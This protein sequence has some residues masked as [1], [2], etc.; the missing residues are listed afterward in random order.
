MAAASIQAV[1][2]LEQAVAAIPGNVMFR[3]NLGVLQLA[4]GRFEDAADTYRAA[5]ALRP[6]AAE[7]HN[8]LGIALESLGRL[9]EAVAAYGDAAAIK[10]E[11]AQAHDNQGGALVKLGRLD[12]AAAAFLRAVAIRPDDPGPRTNLGIC[13]RKMNR[14][15]EADACFADAAVSLRR[16]VAL[17]PDDGEGWARLGHVLVL[18]GNFVGMGVKPKDLA[19]LDEARDCLRRALSL[20]MTITSYLMLGDLGGLDDDLVAAGVRA[21]W[22][23]IRREPGHGGAM[24]VLLDYIYRRDRLDLMHGARKRLLRSLPSPEALGET[25]RSFPVLRTWAMVRADAGFIDRIRRHAV[26]PLFGADSPSVAGPLVVATGDDVYM[27]TYAPDLIASIHAH[28]REVPVHLHV[29]DPSRE[30]VDAVRALAATATFEDTANIRDEDRTVY[31]TCGRF[32]LVHELLKKIRGPIIVTDLDMLCGRELGALVAEHDGVDIGIAAERGR[33]GPHADLCARFIYIDN[34]PRS[35]R[36]IELVC[37]YIAEYLGGDESSWMLDQCALYGI[38]EYLDK[39]GE[40]PRLRRW[41]VDTFD[42]LFQRKLPKVVR[43][44]PGDA[45]YP[46]RVFR[47]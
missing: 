34:T 13:F 44:Q 32:F 2:I 33:R 45:R 18:L 5:I 23:L 40:A 20:D 16:S 29:F 17:K 39:R 1:E 24:C 14:L 4:L 9:D 27:R 11:L 12:E 25:V 28:G 43:G 36:Y 10:P 41:D 30:C 22:D 37:Q 46:A 8:G 26:A 47:V 15:A 35:R 42:W 19:L 31:Y 21:A 38:H 3:C 6:G 7:A